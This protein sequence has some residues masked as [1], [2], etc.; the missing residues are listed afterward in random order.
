MKHKRDKN[1]WRTIRRWS[2]EMEM[3]DAVD[4]LDEGDGDEGDGDEGCRRWR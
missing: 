2:Q 4:I 1:T 3:K